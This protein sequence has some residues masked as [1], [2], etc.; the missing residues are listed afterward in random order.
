MKPWILICCLVQACLQQAFGASSSSDAWGKRKADFDQEHWKTV[1]KRLFLQNKLSGRESKEVIQA[2]TGAGAQ[3]HH[4]N[5]KPGHKNAHRDLM[6]SMIKDSLWPE[7]YWAQIRIK[8]HKKGS[9]KHC[10]HPFLLP[11]EWLAQ[12]CA[13][14]QAAEDLKPVTGSRYA[15]HIASTAKELGKPETGFIPVALHGDGVPI[16]G[17][18][19]EQSLDCFTINLPTSCENSTVRVPFTVMQKDFMLSSGETLDDILEVL[20]W[21]LRHLAAGVF[22]QSRHDARDWQEGD[23]KRK[24][25]PAQA[26]PVQAL[27]CE[28]RGDWDFFEQVLK[29][30]AYNRVSGMCW[31]CQATYKN[32]KTS[33]WRKTELTTSQFLYRNSCDRKPVCALFSLPGVEPKVC[34][35]DW[36]HCCDLGIAADI[37]GHVFME[38]LDEMPV[39]GNPDVKCA[40]LWQELQAWYTETKAVNKLSKLTFNM[41]RHKQAAPK[42][43]AKASEVRTLVHFLPTVCQKYWAQGTLH[44]KTVCSLVTHLAACYAA[45]SPFDPD[46]LAS[47]S[48]KV[49]AL[50]ISLEQ[51]ALAKDP[52]DTRTWRIKPKLHLFQHLCEFTDHSPR[53][54]WCYADESVMGD[55]GKLFTRRGGANSPGTAAKNMLQ[56]WCASKA[57]LDIPN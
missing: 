37:I 39:T 41:F 52:D 21:S 42:L 24:T 7:L 9:I 19:N 5:L 40:A 23:K 54:Y 2:A 4:L 30:P 56:K 55:F 38:L 43:T 27:L 46:T 57:F 50:Y 34:R 18:L 25:L 31:M 53:D 17:T 26:L 3:G 32:F 15:Q 1:S 36:M 33:E 45:L 8:D 49:A 20:C 14:P 29:F 47:S 11:H 10:W 12:Y 16:Q 22:P 6:R 28:I 48:K 51:E 35:P 44:Q 13:L